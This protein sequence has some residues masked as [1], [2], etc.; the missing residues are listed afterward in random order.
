MER[1]T[2]HPPGEAD[3]RLSRNTGIFH[4]SIWR[5]FFLGYSNPDNSSQQLQVFPI[6]RSLSLLSFF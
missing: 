2:I 5:D 3:S 1:A 4:P 6:H